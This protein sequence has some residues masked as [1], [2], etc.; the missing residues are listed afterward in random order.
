[1]FNKISPSQA[2]KKNAGFTLIELLVVIAII[3]ILA[4]ILFPVFGRAR[5]NARRASCQSNLKQIGL[6]MAQYLQDFDEK[7]P[8]QTYDC[9]NAGNGGNGNPDCPR[10]MDSTYTYVKSEQIYTCPSTTINNMYKYYGNGR[11][12]Y[13]WGAQWWLGTYVMNVSYWGVASP[14]RGLIDGPH[15]SDVVSPSTTF[16]VLEREDNPNPNAEVAWGYIS[17]TNASGF[18]N[19]S[20]SPPQMTTII[21][22]HMDTTNVLYADGHVKALNLDALN[23]RSSDGYLAGFTLA[24][25]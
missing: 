25:D 24:D 18:L 13:G 10:W 12:T 23:K 8:R 7:Y 20:A 21:A 4:A 14:K 15:A 22:R 19:K 11:N 2:A 6:G 5:E 17:D 16:V 1:M 3:A 9:Y